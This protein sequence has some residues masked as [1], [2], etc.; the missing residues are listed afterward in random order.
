MSTPGAPRA[1]AAPPR[2]P[3]PGRDIGRRAA[4]RRRGPPSL[5]RVRVRVRVS[6]RVR[7]RIRVRVRVRVRVSV[8]VRVRFRVRVRVRSKVRGGR[9]I[10]RGFDQG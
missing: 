1:G 8:R 10:I 6:V 7:V 9:G 2:A 3:W 5:V 4:R